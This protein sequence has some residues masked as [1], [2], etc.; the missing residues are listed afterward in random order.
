MPPEAQG[1][2]VFAEREQDT[3]LWR[4]H[5][6]V[7]WQAP[8]PNERQQDEKSVIGA[9][10]TYIRHHGRHEMSTKTRDLQAYCS[11]WCVTTRT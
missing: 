7:R 3:P 2:H 4:R 9:R 1:A 6:R 5:V 11:G 10:K 8:G